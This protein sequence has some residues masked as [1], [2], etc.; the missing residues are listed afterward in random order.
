[1]S[2]SS[3]SYCPVELNLGTKK[4]GSSLSAQP[5][6][7][8][9]PPEEQVKDL[10]PRE[11]KLRFDGD[12]YTPEWVRGTGDMYEG[13]CRNCTPGRW[14]NLK[15]SSYWSHMSYAHGISAATGGSVRVDNST[16]ATGG[17]SMS[18]A[19]PSMGTPAAIFAS[20]AGRT[21]KGVQKRTIYGRR[22]A[23]EFFEARALDTLD[24]VLSKG[25][26]HSQAAEGSTLE[27][28]SDG[29]QTWKQLKSPGAMAE[30][31]DQTETNYWNSIHVCRE[32]EDRELTQ[33]YEAQMAEELKVKR[34]ELAKERASSDAKKREFFAAHRS[35]SKV[36][37]ESD[38]RKE[39]SHPNAQPSSD[40]HTTIS[41]SNRAAASKKEETFSRPPGSQPPTLGSKQL[42][43]GSQLPT[44]PPGPRSKANRTRMPKMSACDHCRKLK[45]KVS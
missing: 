26:I 44:E 13:L 37:P 38:H 21:N 27:S 2:S 17:S 6:Q 15:T 35:A 24:G 33:C 16:R 20:S 19:R 41:Q 5:Y 23:G 31:R 11:Q 14:L 8:P 28:C 29:Q 32:N 1:M 45:S 18:L 4:S 12:L 30:L 40:I 43:L 36:Q 9:N 22:G 42:T 34:A 39:P 3:S 10:V 7:P 25:D